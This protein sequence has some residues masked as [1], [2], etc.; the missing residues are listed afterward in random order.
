[1]VIPDRKVVN[2]YDYP[3]H[4]SRRIRFGEKSIR[5]GDMLF[6]AKRMMEKLDNKQNKSLAQS[7]V[8]PFNKTLENHHRNNKGQ[9][10]LLTTQCGI[11][12]MTILNW[13]ELQLRE[14]VDVLLPKNTDYNTNRILSLL[15][16]INIDQTIPL[17][18]FYAVLELGS[19]LTRT[20]ENETVF[21]SHSPLVCIASHQ[22]GDQTTL[23][24]IQEGMVGYLT[25]SIPSTA[26]LKEL[27]KYYI[28]TPLEPSK[29]DSL[30]KLFSMITQQLTVISEN[31]VED[32]ENKDRMELLKSFSDRCLLSSSRTL[33]AYGLVIALWMIMQK[34]EKSSFMELL[35]KL[36]TYPE[37][38]LAHKNTIKQ[39][40]HNLLGCNPEFLDNWFESLDSKIER[41]P[42]ERFYRLCV[43]LVE[44]KDKP[45]Q[46]KALDMWKR[47]KGSKSK[48]IFRKSDEWVDY[49][50]KFIPLLL[51]LLPLRG[52]EMFSTLKNEK[53]EK[54][55][56]EFL[57]NVV[58]SVN[59]ISI[60]DNE[61][62]VKLPFIAND[63]YNS[64]KTQLSNKNK[65]DINLN[66][67]INEVV[68]LRE[69]FVKDLYKFIEILY[70][71]SFLE[72]AHALFNF[73]SELE[74]LEKVPESLW[75]KRW[76]C[77]YLDEE[78]AL[79]IAQ[80]W[81]D[82]YGTYG[83][84]I[85]EIS[86]LLSL[87]ANRLVKKND[88]KSYIY[89]SQIWASIYLDLAAVV[90]ADLTMDKK[91]I[92]DILQLITPRD[93]AFLL[94]SDNL[95]IWYVKLLQANSKIDINK[96]IPEIKQ[97]I[98]SFVSEPSIKP[99]WIRDLIKLPEF[100]KIYKGDRAEYLET[101][102][103]GFL[104]NKK[105]KTSPFKN[106]FITISNMFFLL[107]PA[108]RREVTQFYIF[109]TS[110]LNENDLNQDEKLLVQNNLDKILD[111]NK[112]IS[113][114]ELI[115]YFKLNIC[116]N[117]LIIRLM[118]AFKN[119]LNLISLHQQIL[120]QCFENP[121]FWTQTKILSDEVVE[122]VFE[123]LV[124]ALYETQSHYALLGQAIAIH[125]QL[126]PLS[127]GLPNY[128]TN[129]LSYIV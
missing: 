60:E 96:F 92:K 6:L 46:M 70:S 90:E 32:V 45:A 122:A 88:K 22:E 68:D 50:I 98:R 72:H 38:A 126:F 97:S 109:F 3:S 79:K 74:K 110:Y 65:N 85:N 18:A 61:F 14:F 81:L 23:I 93:N 35:A 101:I 80:E 107:D 11:D 124:Q 43:T 69:G 55:M 59:L 13:N 95:F 117:N 49:T 57:P 25:T 102:L 42:A 31:V 10:I 17:K 24:R 27:E 33:N 78:N 83:D 86:P 34:P 75:R 91:P 5:K 62:R 8:Q 76:K 21:D 41:S 12:F 15:A 48:V 52:Y 103:L 105:T 64:L 77:L 9:R 84:S 127:Q 94:S 108:K 7:L 53:M 54:K 123:K 87:V 36:S 89:A 71:C 120:L 67:E 112:D 121:I 30:F 29:E 44:T 129:I 115:N 39:L 58:S 82:N 111:D 118:K 19:F 100:E 106:E 116:S 56:F 1:M 63:I 66:S 4:C 99:S 119:N 20:I 125:K 28:N 104:A 128:M 47:E 2:E 114:E 37:L 113:V 40:S 16:K 73:Q 51:K 26:Q